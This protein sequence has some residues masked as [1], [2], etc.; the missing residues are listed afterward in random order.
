MLINHKRQYSNLSSEYGTL[1][2]VNIQQV[3]LWVKQYR[4]DDEVDDILQHKSQMQYGMSPS[5]EL[6]TMYLP[7]QDE[8]SDKLE[9]S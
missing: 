4:Q 7:Q 8:D 9:I 2:Q 6:H 1:Q 3:E 5:L